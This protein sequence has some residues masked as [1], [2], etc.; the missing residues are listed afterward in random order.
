MKK[1]VEKDKKKKR[2]GGGSKGAVSVFLTIILVPCIIMTCLFDD[3]SRVQLSKAQAH[4]AADL[5][6]HSLLSNYDS[7]LKED[8]GLVA[9]CQDIDKEYAKAATYFKGMMAAQGI[10]G[11]ESDLFLDYLMRLQ[12]GEISDFL[13]TDL[14]SAEVNSLG[15]AGSSNS[16]GGNPA[17]LEDGIVEFMK[18]RG[19]IEIVTKVVDRLKALKLDEKTRE[20]DLNE[21]VQKAKQEYSEAE[22]Q[23]LKDAFY[24][25]AA[26]YQYTQSQNET[27]VPSEEKYRKIA[28]DV[29]NI[30]DDLHG[31]TEVI[32]LYY[33]A[34]NRI[35]VI[36]FPN[37]SK[38]MFTSEI[39]KKTIGYK[40]P[41]G[42]DYYLSKSTFESIKKDLQDNFRTYNNK[43]IEAAG[44]IGNA[45]SGLEY[46]EGQ[47]N[48]AIYCMKMQETVNQS[49]LGEIRQY[50]EKLLRMYAKIKAA[51]ECK[52]DPECEPDD[53]LPGDWLTIL[54]GYGGTFDDTFNAYL[55][56]SGGNNTYSTVKDRYYNQA[57]AE[58]VVNKVR[59]RS[60]QFNSK[61]CGGSI[62]IGG[63]IS[64]VNGDYGPLK[65]QIKERIKQLDVAIDGGKIKI[66]GKEYKVKALKKLME[67]AADMA[68]KLE[69]WNQ[70]AGSTHTEYADKDKRE[71][72]SLMG[73][74]EDS[75]GSA[76]NRQDGES[77]QMAR[78]IT[79]ESVTELETRLKNIR[80][81][82]QKCLD[83]LKEMK[84]GISAISDI[85]DA[86]GLITAATKSV[87]PTSTSAIS[88]KLSEGKSA[89]RGYADQ[90]IKPAKDQLFKAPAINK[91]AD[92]NDPV[93]DAAHNWPA[94]YKYLH[95]KFKGKIEDTSKAVDE[96]EKNQKKWKEEQEKAEKEAKNTGK[97]TEGKGTSLPDHT[98]GSHFSGMA[99]AKALVNTIT[100]L[101]NGN[102]SQI[103]DEAYVVEYIMD[104]FSWSSFNN[105]G[106]YKI[107][108]KAADINHNNYPY[109]AEGWDEDN[110]QKI[111]ENQSLTNI[112]RDNKHNHAFLGEAEYVL[113]GEASLDKNLEKAYMD[114][115]KLR[116]LVNTTS[117][118]QCYYTPKEVTGQTIH[119]TAL[120]VASATSGIIPPIVT[121][122]LLITAL[123]AAESGL[124]L[125]ILKMGAPVTVYKT[126]PEQW[127]CSLAQDGET[128]VSF[129]TG[130]KPGKV[131]P[132]DPNGMYYSDYIYIFLLLMARSGGNYYKAML[133]RTG[134]LIQA[135][136]RKIE[137]DS[138]FKLDKSLVY[139]KLKS[140]IQ[141]KPLMLSLPIVH[142]LP[143]S[144]IEEFLNSLN[145]R[146]YEIDVIRGYS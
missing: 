42:D 52:Q 124:D 75:A 6:L 122:C 76:Q 61:Y 43:I 140:E 63:F 127:G 84:Y 133:N 29:G 26:I 28:E 11:E 135:N 22:S 49:D 32:T 41:E 120:A 45:C 39:T 33:A 111:P 98:G 103:R 91:K 138:S 62:D 44:R 141:V 86:N 83:S 137:K 35:Y 145:W 110:V 132:E 16:M 67:E 93:I 70:K 36:D 14:Q 125:K 104:M 24:T 13:K 121:K 59:N 60:Y 131:A 74:T 108:R 71:S 117:G 2:I 123:A 114:I 23:L 89:A 134:D 3:V 72:D 47:T 82:L 30:W 142:T 9:S 31:V 73:V 119:M 99:S 130:L 34:T 50:G 1:G 85:N 112:H 68:N 69:K 78:R 18:Y 88:M 37:M 17:L 106:K 96:A 64:R 25:Y 46:T 12:S 27:Q 77:L 56:R 144:G 4:S 58:E 100:L 38:N 94:L 97:Y 19:P 79:A 53:E 101:A 109:Q 5:A 128:N 143:G 10:S 65:D 21:P 81:D 136:M 115:Y 92:G 118:F 126:K 129:D 48:P 40:A 139:F 54:D 51:K 102:V 87:V 20:A 146:Q 55:R 113:Y 90:L 57:H 80:S 107:N 15:G 8:Y 95:E 7:K 105:E 66:G 116:L